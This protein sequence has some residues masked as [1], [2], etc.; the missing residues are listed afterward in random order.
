MA[1]TLKYENVKK[2]GGGLDAFDAVDDFGSAMAGV[3]GAVTAFSGG[4]DLGI[5]A[6]SG[7]IIKGMTSTLNYFFDYGG[8]DTYERVPVQQLPP[9]RIDLNSNPFNN[10]FDP[11]PQQSQMA[12]QYGLE[13][14][15]GF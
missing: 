11:E 14:I 6:L 4:A 2:E 3:G 1:A 13:N 5:G 9:P 12:S 10:Y 8:R 7:G 15:P